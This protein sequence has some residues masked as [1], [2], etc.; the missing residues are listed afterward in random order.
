VHGGNAISVPSCC[1]CLKSHFLPLLA[2]TL[3]AKQDACSASVGVVLFINILK[4]SGY[5][6]CHQV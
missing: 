2:T 6:T 1:C 5:F 3:T 4:C